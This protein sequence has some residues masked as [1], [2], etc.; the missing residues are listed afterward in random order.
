MAI[1]L[2]FLIRYLAGCIVWGMLL[3][4]LVLLTGIGTLAYLQSKGEYQ[5]LRVVDD[6]KSL[7]IIAYTFWSLAGLSFLI[8]LCLIKKIT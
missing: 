7:E 3:I 6:Q 1:V 2:T 5:E 8:I 4:Y